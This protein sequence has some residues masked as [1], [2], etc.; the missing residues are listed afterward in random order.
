M[1]KNEAENTALKSQDTPFAPIDVINTLENDPEAAV[2]NEAGESLR[3]S[4]E[5]KQE[6]KN[7]DGK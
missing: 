5:E 6:T 1:S 7:T 3:N 4:R 2:G